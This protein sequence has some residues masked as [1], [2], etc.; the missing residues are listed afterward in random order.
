MAT[1]KSTTKHV[2][3]I[4]FFLHVI[5]INLSCAFSTSNQSNGAPKPRKWAQPN[6]SSNGRRFGKPGEGAQ[7]S[8]KRR[9]GYELRNSRG[10]RTRRQKPPRWETEGDALFF[11]AKSDDSIPEVAGETPAE[12]LHNLLQ[13]KQE[14]QSEKK[15]T[16]KKIQQVSKDESPQKSLPPNM[17]WGT[18]ST[19]PILSP[20]LKAMYDLP[21]PI[22]TESFGPITAK[23]N[24]VIAA[25][26][27]SGKSLAYLVPLMCRVSRKNFGSVLVVTPTLEL[28]KQIQSV[29]DNIW[30]PTKDMPGSSVCIIRAEMFE[31]G[32]TEYL[33]DAEVLN[34]PIIA[35]TAGAL[36]KWLQ[37]T[38]SKSDILIM[39]DNLETV[40]LDEADR[41]LQ[42]EAMARIEHDKRNGAT[43]LW[44]RKKRLLKSDAMAL[45]DT[46][47]RQGRNFFIKSRNRVQLICASATV[48]R[49]LRRQVMEL[50]DATSVEMGSVLVCADSRVGKDAD[51]RKS[52]LLPASINHFYYLVPEDATETEGAAM[53]KDMW[54]VMRQLPPGPTLV[55]PGKTGVKV[56]ADTLMTECGMKY[57]IT[58][59]DDIREAS[60]TLNLESVDATTNPAA[61]WDETAVF[62]VSE[63][64]ARG[65]DIPN[66]A[67]VV[68]AGGPPN[69]PAAYAHLAG[70]TGRVGK[71]G[72][73]VTFVRG[74]KGANRVVNISYKLGLSFLP[75]SITGSSE[76][77]IDTSTKDEKVEEEPPNND[78][79]TP[80]SKE[81]LESYTIPVLKDLL[82]ERGEMVSGKKAELV[83]RLLDSS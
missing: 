56:A 72:K 59:Q 1:L 26:T 77:T 29:V 67:Y 47:A 52:S 60:K 50:T 28:A 14:E 40:V 49:T 11:V 69:S 22:Q 66:V 25:A 76:S 58:L 21:T 39:L 82:K 7:A 57:T 71:E 80:L 38:S 46:I 17:V 44:E 19:G 2:L 54:Q 42:T 79:S 9:K 6:T 35:G 20:K 23:N 5:I 55:F 48:G 73:V 63:K 31:E 81:V 32:S 75:L 51:E 3:L 15:K 12:V 8:Q 4:S 74:M 33:P 36:L 64:L 41:I 10:V 27:G 37:S 70:R 43:D 18:L 78:D 45:F 53:I 34:T 62:V 61:S 65:L 30:T 24:V 68:L 83:Q 16:G 13:M